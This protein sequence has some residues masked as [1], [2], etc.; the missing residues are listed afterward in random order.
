MK[1]PLR[2]L[3]PAALSRAL[4]RRCAPSDSRLPIWA[5]RHRAFLLAQP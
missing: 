1:Q 5:V 4:L 2:K 3:D